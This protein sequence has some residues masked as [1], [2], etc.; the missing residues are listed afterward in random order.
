MPPKVDNL[1]NDIGALQIIE[2]QERILKIIEEKDR[3]DDATE[4]LKLN[5]E[6]EE[7]GKDEKKEEEEPI[8]IMEKENIPPKLCKCE[9]AIP[10]IDYLCDK[11]KCSIRELQ[12]MLTNVE[13]RHDIINHLR[14]AVYLRT[15]H[16]RPSHRNFPV[17]CNDL[18]TQSAADVQALGGYL[19]IKAK[20]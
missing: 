13:A 17:R 10:L 7:E 19:D 8:I 1:A 18:S 6:E 9:P 16:I 2:E 5:K 4:P 20:V 14:Y 12:V 11:Y 15:C 3:I